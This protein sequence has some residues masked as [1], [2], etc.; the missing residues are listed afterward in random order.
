[1]TIDM[2]ALRGTRIF[3]D[4]QPKLRVPSAT[5]QTLARGVPIYRQGEIPRTV[6]LVLEGAVKEAESTPEGK[7]VILALH[8]PHQ[9]FGD[10]ITSHHDLPT[11]ASALTAAKLLCIPREE[12]QR[13]I[14]DDEEVA[15]TYL[16]HLQRRLVESWRLVRMLSRYTTEARLKS[17]L[18][19]LSDSWGQPGESGI[20]IGLELTHRILADLTGASREKVTRAL[21]ILADKGLVSTVRRRL[22]IPSL[23]RLQRSD[24]V[25][26]FREP[27]PETTSDATSPPSDT[28]STR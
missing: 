2:S 22:V 7:E 24:E 6:Y 4:L 28:P 12:W 20:E 25:F 21:G 16:Q 17:L 8:G 19:F 27:A 11:G 23:E 3:A 14:R 10:V 13:L 5:E 26:G 15:R 9:L 18:L 1:M